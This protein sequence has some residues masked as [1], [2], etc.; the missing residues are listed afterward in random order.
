MR[1]GPLLVLTQHEHLLNHVLSR[2]GTELNLTAP[3]HAGPGLQRDLKF[4]WH[5][6]AQPAA[7]EL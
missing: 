3:G 1:A 7:I 6:H 5:W 2:T 4:H